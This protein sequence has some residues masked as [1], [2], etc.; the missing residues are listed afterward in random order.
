MFSE[1]LDH[2]DVRTYRILGVIATL[3][4]VQHHSSELG[5]R[6]HLVTHT[7]TQS[8]PNRHD[9]QR[10]PRER[11]SSNAPACGQSTTVAGPGAIENCIPQSLT[12]PSSPRSY[13]H[14]I[15]EFADW[16]CS[17]PRLPF[18]KTVVTR[19]GSSSSRHTM[20]A[21]QSTSN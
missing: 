19:C 2:P 21:P 7:L 15:R 4:F 9:A 6:D 8:S 3:E 14:A 5:H 12:S 1:S 13:E 10:P 17:E 11:V 16:Y 18:N 20:P